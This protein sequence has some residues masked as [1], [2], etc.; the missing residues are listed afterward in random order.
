MRGQ[1]GSHQVGKSLSGEC[2]VPHSPCGEC[3]PVWTEVVVSLAGPLGPMEHQP[4]DLL[5][6]EGRGRPE[7]SSMAVSLSLVQT[8]IMKL[9]L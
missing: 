1:R 4:L 5:I 8:I 3:E 2:G 7:D 9:W 6:C